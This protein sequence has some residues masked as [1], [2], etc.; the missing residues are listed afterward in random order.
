[1]QLVENDF[2]GTAYGLGVTIYTSSAYKS[3]YHP[4]AWFTIHGTGDFWHALVL[5]SI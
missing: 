1:M 3:I 2:L 4:V 5:S